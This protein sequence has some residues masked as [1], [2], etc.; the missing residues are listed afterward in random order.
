MA[1]I[2]EAASIIAV[3]QLGF[4]L[5]STLASFIGDYKEAGN[6]ID[7]LSS[8]IQLTSVSLQQ[9]GDLANGNRL[10]GE[11]AV[12]QASN[13]RK[14]C[15]D[16]LQE[17]RVILKRKDVTLDVK[18]INKEEIDISCYERW[19]WATYL[20]SRLRIPRL[21]LGRLKIDLMLVYFSMIVLG[22]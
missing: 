7:S 12:L 6:R 9:L 1:G 14:R 11:N 4:A 10:Q 8:E 22:R 19:R 18:T 2:G 21:E 20:R 3:A 16:V 13:L 15:D 5:A 17:I